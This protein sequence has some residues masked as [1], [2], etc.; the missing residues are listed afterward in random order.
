MTTSYAKK[1]D[2]T[3]VST[4]LGTRIDQNAAQIRSTATK[5]DQVEINASTAIS[6]AAAAKTVANQAQE[7]ANAAQTKYTELKNRA[8]ATDEELSL[9]HI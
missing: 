5:V 7:A 6:D 4:D 1:S 9:I 3:Q 8:D 2:L